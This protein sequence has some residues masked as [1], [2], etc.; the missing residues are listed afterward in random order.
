[1]VNRLL[2]VLFAL[3]WSGLASAQ[4][5]ITPSPFQTV[6]DSNG[7]PINGACVWTYVAG[8]STPINTYTSVTL[9]S[10]NTNPIVA[11]SAGRYTAF[12][13]PG[14]SYKFVYEAACTPPSHA[15]VFR[16]A[17][18]IS[19]VPGS[20]SGLD[21]IGTAGETMLAGQCAY[22]SN[23]SGGKTAGS[24]Y[25]CTSAN[26]YSSTSPVI[27]VTPS[28]II[29]GAVGSIRI[30]GT[31]TSVSG[32]SVGQHYYVAS[33]AGDLS[34]T[35]PREIGQADSATSLVVIGSAPNR[36]VNNSIVQGRLTLTA[37]TC[38][39]ATDV[40]AATTVRFTP[41]DGNQIALYNGSSWD[42]VIFTELSIAVPAT[43]S[44]MYDTFVY[45]SSGTATLELTA[46]T[47]DTTR[48][49]ALVAQDGVLSKT[50]A[51]TR[52]YVGSFRTTGVS[53]QTEDSFAKRYVW[54]F[55]NRA[56]RGMRVLEI[57]DT[58]AY[59]TNTYR[60]ANAAAGNQLDFIVGWADTLVEGLVLANVSGNATGLPMWVAIGE[61]ST[62][63]AATGCLVGAQTTFN[64][65]IPTGLQT[66]LKKYPAVG[67]HVWVWLEK[68]GAAT[69]TWYGDNGADG[70][71]SGIHGTIWC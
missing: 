68:A 26:S 44:T 27:G 38:V 46:W 57:T 70:T 3:L 29:S 33:T 19:A 66:S 22:L 41:C 55:Y 11:D 2:L 45:S 4:G 13:S 62:S 6:L 49:T 51:L 67:R 60:Q 52:R 32:L 34:T 48:A 30:G 31:V 59:S 65:S 42:A 71:Q 5:T 12:L 37:A 20:S 63:A 7:S 35:G 39:T 40:T 16:T 1:M 17:D 53:G 10:A 43:T 14:S 23:G 9:G 64:T 58:W 56:L 18:N 24:W 36:I 28:A 61:D 25:L 8:T 50:G 69:V 15:S 21:V 47:N 54:N